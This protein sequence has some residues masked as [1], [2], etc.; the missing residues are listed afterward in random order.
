M[1]LCLSSV[2]FDVLT[3]LSGRT[4]G[5]GAAGQMMGSQHT[6]A[7]NGTCEWLQTCISSSP[8]SLLFFFHFNSDP[9]SECVSVLSCIVTHTGCLIC[10][11]LCMQTQL[12]LPPSLKG[13]RLF[14]APW[15]TAEVSSFNAQ[16]SA[17]VSDYRQCYCVHQ[18]ISPVSYSPAVQTSVICKGCFML[19]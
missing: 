8:P 3:L 1:L 12:H 18:A 4:V 7:P 19:Q 17:W 10:F 11:F 2:Q 15:W 9:W 6:G 14:P 13:L 16:S 5:S